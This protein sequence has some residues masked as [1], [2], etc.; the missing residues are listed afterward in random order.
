MSSPLLSCPAPQEE[1][2]EKRRQEEE[3]RRR[4]A[5]EMRREIQRANEYQMRLKEEREQ[6][7]KVRVGGRAGYIGRS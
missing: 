3:E 2:E 5:E 7:L 1:A 6:Q 4:K